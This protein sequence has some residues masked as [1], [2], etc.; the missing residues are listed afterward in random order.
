M[1][2]R[3]GWKL[4]TRKPT[5]APASSDA[6]QGRGGGPVGA[7]EPG[8]AVAEEE[9]GQR[10]DADHAG[11]Q[12]VEP[13]DHVDRVDRRHDQQP[14]S[15]A[16]WAG[17]R[18]NWL[19]CASVKKKNWTPKATRN[20]AASTWPP[21][22]VSAS[23]SKRSSSTPT[24]QISAPAI[25][26]I[27]ASRKTQ[28][29]AGGEERQLTGDEVRRHEAA[30]H[31]QPAEVGDRLV[32]H[33]AVADLG[34]RAG[35]ER[36][37][38]GHDREQVGDRGGHQ[39]DEDVLPHAS[40]ASATSG[41]RRARRP[42]RCVRVGDGVA[43]RLEHLVEL[44]EAERAEPQHPAR[45]AGGVDDGR[46]LAARRR[47]GVDDDLDLLAQH[48]LGLAA[49]VAAGRPV[50]LAELTASGPVRS[51]ISRATGWSG[52]RTATVPR[53]SPRSHC[54]EAWAW[55]TRVSA[56]GQNSST[57]ARA[58]VGTRTASAS[59]VVAAETS[60]GGG[61]SRPRPLASRSCLDRVLVEGVGG[62]AVDGVG[63]QHHEASALDGQ[64][65]GLDRGLALLVG[66]GRVALH[67]HKGHGA[68]R[69]VVNRGRP[70]RS[71]WSRTSVQ[72]PVAVEHRRH[73]LALDVGVLDARALPRAGAV[74]RRGP[75]APGS[76]RDR[77]RRR[78]APGAGRGRGLPGRPTPRPRAGRTAGCRRRRRRCRPGRRRR[79]RSRP[80][81]GRRRCRRGCARPSGTPARRAPRRAPGPAAPRARPPWRSRRSRCRGRPRPAPRAAWP[82]RRPSR[83]AARSRAG[84]RTRPVRRRARRGG[85]TPARSGAAAA[86]G[87]RA[88]PP[89]RRTRR[90]AA[91]GTS[92]TSGS[93]DRSVP[94]AWASSSAASCSGL[95]TPASRRVSSAVARSWR[96]VIAFRGPRGSASA[97][98]DSWGDH[99]SSA[100]RRSAR[101]IATQE[102][103]TGWR[104]PSRT[105][106]RL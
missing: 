57:S 11:R 51:R 66:G 40:A 42:A 39:E 96:G 49:S 7:V 105:W 22:L 55:Q 67:W 83:P 12:P 84:A 92:S 4:W 25:S 100:A 47:T 98:S 65:G 32:V 95:G 87:P 29:R 93:R 90:S 45:G 38:A 68:S 69:A 16:R 58:H 48:L 36:D 43:E 18:E 104:S 61:M 53:V 56:P 62:Q 28:R 78:T 1:K 26:T 31:R 30:Q 24:A 70:A 54:S 34:D 52:I 79:W 97:A 82:P 46:G 63:R 14:V 3:A 94:R 85:T 19:P 5:Q 71:R 15:T 59:R 102:S 74:R 60:T 86:R 35:A 103:R 21:S 17:S 23:S 73:R 91:A 76:R 41:P 80:G 33:V 106:S 2:S 99:E 81:A 72:R 37:L 10:A 50:R 64:A 75:P 13:V 27:P 8:Q 20:P 9:E 89:G 6:E 77:R 88:G 44:L 101:S